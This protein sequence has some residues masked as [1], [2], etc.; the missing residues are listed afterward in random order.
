MNEST[1]AEVEYV[2]KYYAKY[3]ECPYISSCEG[4]KF[5][6]C[7][8]TKEEIEMCFNMCLEFVFR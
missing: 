8:G 5:N 7:D 6:A 2:K 4:T 3:G 1:K